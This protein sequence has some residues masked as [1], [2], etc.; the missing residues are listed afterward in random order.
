METYAYDASLDYLTGANYGDGLPNETPTWS[1]DAAGNRTDS[2]VDNLNRTTSIGGVSTSC[3]VLGNRLSLGSSVSY[4]WDCLNR[5][6]SYT[7]SGVSNSYWYR[8][9]GMRVGKLVVSNGTT[10][11]YRYDGQM[12][13]EDI[14]ASGSGTTVN[15]YGLGAR[16]IDLI[17]S[18]S[19]NGLSY[20]YPIYD[21][22]GN[23]IGTLTR[24][25]SASY[26]T[27]N[28]REYDA[29]GSIRNGQATGDPKGRY[30]AKLGHK[31]DDESGLAYM[32]ARYYDSSAGRFLSEDTSRDG[33]N[34][35]E[36]GGNIPTCSEDRDGKAP[37][38]EETF[39]EWYANFV[40][41]A[42]TSWQANLVA[43]SFCTMWSA[44]LVEESA[45]SFA[46]SNSIDYEM[47]QKFQFVAAADTAV[48]GTA[49]IG[50]ESVEAQAA[51]LGE[52]YA[53]GLIIS[54]W[55]ILG[56]DL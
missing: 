52:A 27:G 19:E 22:H 55:I 4:G 24:S 12:G 50:T 36:Y 47:F 9:D 10:T 14:D 39:A 18:N 21:G 28:V 26:S 15:D 7:N 45:A 51:A 8:A 37:I 25:G 38:S 20:F 29:W 48:F 46:E 32:R 41:A 2:V 43:R 17:S 53:N 44:F 42:I 35:F 33:R 11:T 6:G 40:S 34:W 3:D 31:Q 16:G 30:C 54:T 49:V 5:M 13:F 56:D 1:Y 23:M